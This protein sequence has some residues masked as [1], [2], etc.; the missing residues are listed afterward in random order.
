MVTVL[1]TIVASAQPC[2][3]SLNLARIRPT[4]SHRIRRCLPWYDIAWTRFK[5]RLSRMMTAQNVRDFLL[6]YCACFL[7]VSLFVW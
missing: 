2:R 1:E 4:E 6:A 7:A 3:M 5:T